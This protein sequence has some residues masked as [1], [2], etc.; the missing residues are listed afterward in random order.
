HQLFTAA[1]IRRVE[2]KAEAELRPSRGLL[3]R[4]PH[5]GQRQQAHH[6]KFLHDR[7]SSSRSVPRTQT[8]LQREARSVQVLERFPTVCPQSRRNGA[9]SVG[10]ST[11][12]AARVG[13]PIN[14]S[15]LVKVVRRD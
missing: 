14:E 9:R 1:F 7:P 6:Y 3:L 8:A 11:Y 4:Q 10:R 5:H 13:Q 15:L 2:A 12:S